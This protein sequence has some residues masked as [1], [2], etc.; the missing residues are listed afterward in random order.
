MIHKLKLEDKSDTVLS[1]QH[2]L[3]T[4]FFRKVFLAYVVNHTGHGFATNKYY[5]GYAVKSATIP[6][7]GVS[8][9]ILNQ[10]RNFTHYSCAVIILFNTGLYKSLFSTGK[11]VFCFCELFC[12]FCLLGVEFDVIFITLLFKYSMFLFSLIRNNF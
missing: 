10:L 9:A 6:D 3:E 7:F 1:E 2:F 12:I 5:F 8:T 11:L 4:K